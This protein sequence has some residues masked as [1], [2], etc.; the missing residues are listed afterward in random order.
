LGRL[1]AEKDVDPAD[2]FFQAHF[3]QDPVQPGSLGLEAM[4]QLLQVFMRERGRSAGIAH[5]RFEPFGPGEAVTWRYRGQVLPTHRRVTVEV[6]V[7][8]TGSDARGWF[9]RADGWLWVDGT[10]IYEARNLAM[11]IVAD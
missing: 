1:R 5:P 9:A 3:Y 11:R 2:W 8:E 4:L 10:R 7:T 6:E